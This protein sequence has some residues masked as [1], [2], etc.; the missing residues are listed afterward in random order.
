MP[1][2]E[3]EPAGEVRFRALNG[4]VKHVPRHFRHQ[5][6][7][8]NHIEIEFEHFVESLHSVAGGGHDEIVRLKQQF[9]GVSQFRIVIDDQD[10]LDIEFRLRERTIRIYLRQHRREL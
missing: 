8:D 7:A 1:S 5:E 2:D 6:V 9:Q 3:Q 10:A 4:E